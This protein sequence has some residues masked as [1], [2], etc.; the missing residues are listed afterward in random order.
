MV[1]C[2]ECSKPVE[3]DF[4]MTTCPHCSVVF[5]VELDG[6]VND[7]ADNE[8]QEEFSEESPEEQ[9]PADDLDV[10]PMSFRP[11]PEDEEFNQPETFAEETSEEETQDEEFFAKVEGS[12][13]EPEDAVDPLK[14]PLGL[15][16]FD[17]SGGF[18]LANGELLYDVVVQGLDSADLKKDIFSALMDKRFALSS[19]DMRRGLKNGVLTLTGVNPV[20]AMLI[21]LKMQEYD[22]SVEWRQRHFAQPTAEVEEPSL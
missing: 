16:R 11:S 14:D 21:V 8:S 4:G 22:V 3:A 19:E 1:K 12:T 10:E 15:Q 18:E 6:S 2:P 20:R 7:P 5:M 13:T 9:F 17:E